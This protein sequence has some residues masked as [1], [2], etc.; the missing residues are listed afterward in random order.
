MLEPGEYQGIYNCMHPIAFYAVDICEKILEQIRDP[1][2][3]TIFAHA[4]EL[5]FEEDVLNL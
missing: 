4:E 1:R 5:L 3:T 2:I